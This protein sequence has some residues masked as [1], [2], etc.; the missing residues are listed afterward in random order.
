MKNLNATVYTFSDISEF[1]KFLAYCVEQDISVWRLYWDERERDQRCYCVDWKERRCYYADRS[2]YLQ[3][4][5][6]IYNPSFGFDQFGKIKM[7]V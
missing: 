4:G 1:G 3:E 2:Y 6:K 7:W 5:Y